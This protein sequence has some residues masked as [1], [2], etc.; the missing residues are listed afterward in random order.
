VHRYALCRP[1]FL[2]RSLCCDLVLAQ[3]T[4]AHSVHFLAAVLAAGVLSAGTTQ[5]QIPGTQSDLKGTVNVPPDQHFNGTLNI[6]NGGTDVTPVNNWY[7]VRG[8]E[9]K[10]PEIIEP[11]PIDPE[12]TPGPTPPGEGRTPAPTP[13]GEFTAGDN[14]PKPPAIPPRR[15]SPIE[16]LTPAANAAIG[17]FSAVMPVSGS[18][19]IA[20][21]LSEVVW[22]YAPGG[23]S[24]VGQKLL[25]PTP[26]S[27]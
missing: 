1:S 4:L 6:G 8:D 22:A 13:P 15:L 21:L 25:N 26:K 7:L 11:P 20:K 27:Q 23:I 3:S 10:R 9:I 17:T 12:P 18:T 2:S 5:A 16:A 14:L 19:P 24:T